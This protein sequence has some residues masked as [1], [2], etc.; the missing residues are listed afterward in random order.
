MSL[1]SLSDKPAST[2]SHPP[3]PANDPRNAAAPPTAAPVTAPTAVPTGRIG[4][5]IEEA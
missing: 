5:L 1:V 2:V 3:S 4:L